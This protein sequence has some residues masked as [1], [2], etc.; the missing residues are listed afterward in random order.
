ML[1]VLLSN[2]D[3]VEALGL[4]QLYA[5]LRGM[6]TC[7][8]RQLDVR[9]SAP[10]TNQSAMS[11]KLTIGGGLEVIRRDCKAKEEEPPTYDKDAWA[12]GVTGTP[13]D[14]IRVGL[15]VLKQEKWRPDLVISGVNHGNN[16]GMCSLY[17]GTVGAAVEGTLRGIP[18]I[19]ISYDLRGF[20][21]FDDRDR[22]DMLATIA[23]AV[24]PLLD[25]CFA[26]TD[27]ACCIPRGFTLLVN[28]PNPLQRR[29][30]DAEGAACKFR[31]ARLAPE[32]L[33]LSYSEEST[34]DGNKKLKVGSSRLEDTTPLVQDEKIPFLL[35][36]YKTDIETVKKD[37][38][39]S[40]TLFPLIPA[41][42]VAK[43]YELV[44]STWKLFA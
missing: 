23:E 26:G 10:A 43:A 8:G 39:V 3:G 38:Y 27:G 20:D 1:R 21:E 9:V 25:A 18:S 11:H 2:D 35:Q 17:S 5:V 19:A 29:V 37:G 32:A 34:S 31:L 28:L 4:K 40:V 42:D 24:P 22:R 30:E 41:C 15:Q 6:G 13:V 12:I 14:S 36:Q 44:S 33:F 7:H 16:L